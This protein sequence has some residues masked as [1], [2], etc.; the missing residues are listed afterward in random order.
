MISSGLFVPFRVGQIQRFQGSL[1]SALIRLGSHAG[2]RMSHE[3]SHRVSVIDIRQ[4]KHIAHL[5]RLGL[6]DEESQAFSRQ[7][8]TIIDYFNLLADVDVGGVLPAN[9]MQTVRARMRPDEVVPSS[10]TREE[11][12][13]NAP[14]REGWYLRVAPTFAAAR[15]GADP[16][17][18]E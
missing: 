4:I 18:E 13:A 6:S 8:T 15:G 11:L 1:P 10:I 9:H 7:L 16:E 12:L 5:A 2:A 14:R 3:D 17:C